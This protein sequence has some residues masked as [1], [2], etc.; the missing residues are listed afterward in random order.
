MAT[1]WL[2]R[3]DATATRHIHRQTG[4]ALGLR[5]ALV[6]RRAARVQAKGPT[7]LSV[8][9]ARQGRVTA[10]KSI[11]SR[12]YPESGDDRLLIDFTAVTRS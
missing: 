2:Y 6:E 12:A 10:V 8:H 5:D 7:D 3:G 9:V 11:N 4:R 1:N